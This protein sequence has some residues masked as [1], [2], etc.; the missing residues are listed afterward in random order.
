MATTWGEF[1]AT[2]EK[3]GAMDTDEIGWIEVVGCTT[4]A[5]EELV[6]FRVLIT[7]FGSGR[8]MLEVKPD[9]DR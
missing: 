1:K 3:A 5:D 8:R 9:R 4:P 6:H 2:V 7:E